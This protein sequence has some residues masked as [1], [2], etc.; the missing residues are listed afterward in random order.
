MLLL[1]ENKNVLDK[2]SDIISD[3]D[4]YDNRPSIKDKNKKELN[5]DEAVFH[6]LPYSKTARIRSGKSSL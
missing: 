4:E 6:G 1:V 2:L 5:K 3:E